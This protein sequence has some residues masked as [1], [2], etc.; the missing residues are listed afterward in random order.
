[1]GSNSGGK[2]TKDS[3]K[4][5]RVTEWISQLTLEEK[6][7][8][9]SGSNFVAATGV[10][11]LGIPGLKLVDSVNGVKGSSHING[12]TTLC[13][14]STTCLGATWNVELMEKL[15]DELAVQAKQKGAS[16][17][18]GP[19]VNIHRDP[20]GGRN[21]ECFSEDPLLTGK[22][23]AALVTGIQRGGV[24][25]CPKHFIGNDSETK[26]R[27]YSVKTST[28]GRA[29]REIYLAAFEHLIRDSDPMATMTAYNKVQANNKESPLFCS[30]SPII[31]QIL[32]DEWNYR[33]CV[34][35]DWY[36]TRSGLPTLEANL[37]LEMPGPSVFRGEKLIQEVRE[38]NITKEFIE[39]RV[40]NILTLIEKT[41]D[42]D[43]HAD[44]KSMMGD[45]ANLLARTIAFEGIVLL[46]NEEKTLPLNFD[47][48]WDGKVAIIGPAALNPPVGGGGSA[49][50]P[51]QYT[52]RPL[53]CLRASHPTPSNVQHSVGFRDH[54]TIPSIPLSIT[55]ARN[56]EEGMDISYFT[57]DQANTV[58]QEFQ[59]TMQTAMIGYLKPP[60][61][62][63][64]FSEYVISTT[65]RPSTTGSHTVAIQATGSFELLVDKKLVLSGEMWPPPSVEDFLFIPQALER[66]CTVRMVARHEYFIQAIVQPFKPFEET[67]EPRIHGAKL[68]FME[69][70]SGEA[71]RDGAVNLASESEISIIF[72]GRNAE[73]ESEGFDLTS[74]HLPDNQEKLIK[75]VSKAS[76]K[77]VLVLFGG[78][79]IDVSEYVDDVDAIVWAHFLGQE[80][81]E[82][83]TDILTGK[84]CPSGRL[85]VSWPKAL[86][87]VGSFS[88]F[89]AVRNSDGDWEIDYVEGLKV[90][91]RNDEYESR[92]RFGFGLS[93][94]AFKY[95]NLRCSIFPRGDGG[96][97]GGELAIEVDV[98]NTGEVRGQEVVQVYIEDPEA[99]MWRPKEEL[100]AFQK[101]SLNAGERQTV[102]LM[103]DQRIA[104]SFWDDRIPEE[105][106]WRV[107]PGGFRIR[108]ED[109]AETVTLDAGFT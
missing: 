81:G 51:P 105:A 58:L 24:A 46:K 36:G 29:M 21:F 71:L 13:F 72:A 68:C 67:G 95:S 97:P 64:T 44:E 50:T 55:R 79:P 33:G 93:Y 25:A 76:R 42:T 9:L 65:I 7:S 109:L 66:S 78:N 106:C 87:D 47:K 108:V 107:E 85:T 104:F 77:T 10:P 90:G 16:V 38:G 61:T 80:G 40:R 17:I 35:S 14:P 94:T 34:I 92:W 84:V 12:S 103:I 27:F 100:K 49:K 74:I 11:R 41:L 91:Y 6:V 102:K 5:D 86:E 22:L 45:K 60:L 32:R 70:Y 62:Q 56:G 52:Q 39:K 69:E 4:A 98:T 101:V 28:D 96:N 15:G 18:L 26:R 8:L 54:Q 82:A 57:Q 48:K 53:G 43:L 89:P 23:A 73:M 2:E 59:P 31:Q 63:E 19:T 30:E 75:E 99:S 1:M 20:R 3:I 88:H 37:D 83:I